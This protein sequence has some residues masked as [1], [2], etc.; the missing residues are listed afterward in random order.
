L[1]QGNGALGM[2]QAAPNRPAAPKNVPILFNRSIVDAMADSAHRKITRGGMGAFFA[3]IEQRDD[4]AVAAARGILAAADQ[5][6]WT[7]EAHAAIEA[8][9]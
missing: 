7:C 1:G 9:A 6:A 3:L 2:L 5:E 8:A 4:P